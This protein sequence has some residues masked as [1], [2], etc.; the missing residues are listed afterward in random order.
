MTSR[1]TIKPRCKVYVFGRRIHH[2]RTGIC[3]TALGLALIAHDWRDR[4]W[5]TID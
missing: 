5:P 4:P 1:L 2:G 3:L